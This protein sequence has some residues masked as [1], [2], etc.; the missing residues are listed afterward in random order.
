MRYLITFSYDGSEFYGYQRQKKL[1]TVQGEIEKILTEINSKKEVTIHASGRTDVGVHAINQ[2][3]HFDLEG[4]HKI[5]NLKKAMNRKFN[6]AIYIKDIEIVA[7]DF[8]A[9]YNV[10]TKTYIYKLNIGEFNPIDRKYIYQFNK[11]LDITKMIEAIKYFTN[12]NDFRA[13]CTGPKENCIRTI[14]DANILVNDNIIIFTFTGNGF[15]RKMIRNIMGLLLEAGTNK[16]NP[17]EIKEILN[18]KE[19]KHNTKPA[20]ACGLYLIDVNYE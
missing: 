5:Y 7:N 4:K 12:T 2:K 10:L 9:R 17:S 14:Y 13:L 8:H 18:S 6:G 20:P 15:L 1:K 11:E 19:R 3:A 16:R